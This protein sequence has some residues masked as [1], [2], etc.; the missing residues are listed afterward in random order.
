MRLKSC[1]FKVCTKYFGEV[2]VI[3]VFSSENYETRVQISRLRPRNWEDADTK[4]SLDLAKVV[5]TQ[6]L[7]RAMLISVSVEKKQ[8]LIK[9]L[10]KIT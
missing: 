1:L 4:S 3:I 8:Y 7:S 5:E 10:F 9:L 2:I 6:T